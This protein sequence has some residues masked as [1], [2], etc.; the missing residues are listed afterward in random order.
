MSKVSYLSGKYYK[1]CRYQNHHP[2]FTRPDIGRDVTIADRR[3]RDDYKP[4][5]VKQTKI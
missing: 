5:G 1:N 3:E 2:Q 4:E